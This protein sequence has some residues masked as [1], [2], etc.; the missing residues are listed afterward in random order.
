MRTELRKELDPFIEKYVKSVMDHMIENY[1]HFVL[2]TDRHSN[3]DQHEERIAD[4]ASKLRFEFVNKYIKIWHDNTICLF[5]VNITA[6]RTQSCSDMALLNAQRFSTFSVSFNGR[7][8]LRRA[9]DS[10]SIKN[11]KWVCSYVE[12][13]SL[14][15]DTLC[16]YMQVY[17]LSVYAHL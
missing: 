15:I 5:V 13:G 11:N 3:S 12:I 16:S 8:Q 17:T 4:W 1:R 14:M 9:L 2:M 6:R 10:V 7:G